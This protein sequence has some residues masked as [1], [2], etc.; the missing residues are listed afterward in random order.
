MLERRF[1]R[2]ADG[3]AGHGVDGDIPEA[4]AGHS[5]LCRKAVERTAVVGMPAAILEAAEVGI[6]HQA[7]VAGLRALDHDDIVF[8][9]VLA[10]VYEFHL[11]SQAA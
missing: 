7:N 6:T 8:V 2:H 11:L 5:D 4:T 9:E 10:L 3:A 1:A